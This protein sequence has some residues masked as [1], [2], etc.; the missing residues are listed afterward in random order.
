[1]TVSANSVALPYPIATRSL[2]FFGGIPFSGTSLRSLEWFVS[3]HTTSVWARHEAW[4]HIARET[5]DSPLVLAPHVRGRGART[6]SSASPFW[7]TSGSSS[8]SASGRTPIHR[9]VLCSTRGR[10]VPVRNVAGPC[11]VRRVSAIPVVAAPSLPYPSLCS[12]GWLSQEDA[13]LG[14][15]SVDGGSLFR[16]AQK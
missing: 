14:T 6:T 1:M 15:C 16:V 12:R 3:G 10:F 8:A 13:G 2:G 4:S 11:S 9:E 7:I 5:G